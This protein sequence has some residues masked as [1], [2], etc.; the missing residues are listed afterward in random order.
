MRSQRIVGV[1]GIH[2][3]RAVCSYGHTQILGGDTQGTPI[4]SGQE[5]ILGAPESIFNLSGTATASSVRGP[6]FERSAE[7]GD[8]W[9][10]CCCILQR[11]NSCL[12]SAEDRLKYIAWRNNSGTAFRARSSESLHGAGEFCVRCCVEKRWTLVALSDIQCSPTRL[13]G[14]FHSCTR[15]AEIRLSRAW[16]NGTSWRC[17]PLLAL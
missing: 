13:Q 16:P 7:A 8:W 2:C 12:F 3:D 11:P 15:R 6:D 17:H 4:P 5:T 1:L 10:F 14:P 9:G